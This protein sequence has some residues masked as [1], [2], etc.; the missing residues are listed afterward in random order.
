[1]P[2][3]Y[4]RSELQRSATN[5]TNHTTQ[6]V[7]LLPADHPHASSRTL[8]DD[9]RSG[10]PPMKENAAPA[11]ALAPPSHKRSK[12]SVSLRSLGR[13]K[14]G[15]KEKEKKSRK[16]KQA[17]ADGDE[18]R[19]KPKKTKSTTSLR[20]L[21]T[22]SRSSKDLRVDAQ[23]Q[24]DKENF[25]PTQTSPQLVDTPIWSQFST[26]PD[27]PASDAPQQQQQQQPYQVE[28]EI[29]RYTPQNYSP[30]KQRDFHAMG[31]PVLQRPTSSG[32]PKSGYF[33]SSTSFMDALTRK[34]SN[35]RSQ[36][37]SRGSDRPSSRGSS[38]AGAMGPPPPAAINTNINAVGRPT[39]L[40]INTI[41]RGMERPK[42][43]R[44]ET[45]VSSID[46]PQYF[47][48]NSENSAR[49][50]ASLSRSSKDYSQQ[51]FVDRSRQTIY[52]TM[53]R[54]ASTSSNDRD[55][56]LTISKRGSRVMAAVAV[57][58]GKAK[59]AVA[60]KEEP[61]LDPKAVDAAFEAVL[62]CILTMTHFQY[63]I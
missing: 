39:S 7:P 48:T 51:P 35:D 20:A 12:S 6:A 21:L 46:R 10:R 40:E 55:Q 59:E 3:D 53:D 9:A 49:S 19:K 1:M 18:G 34:V 50:H 2:K 11:P 60:V 38:K 26:A 25:S 31:P 52:D 62:V 29:A 58:N 37:R 13:S 24:H 32:R 57:F 16:D 54:K 42:S 23:A 27:A 22:K 17:Q 61:K 4:R 30:S 5:E 36:L 45:K 8:T 43:S 14:D 56:S 47:R 28:A 15:D 63:G 44:I 41:P 33:P